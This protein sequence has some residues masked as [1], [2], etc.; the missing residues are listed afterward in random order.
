MSHDT[1]ITEHYAEKSTPKIT[2]VIKDEDGIVIP[3]GSLNTLTLTLY[4]KATDTL[5]GSRSAQQDILEVNG[6]SVDGSGNFAL[7]LTAA[8]MAIVT[9]AVRVETHIALIEWTYNSGLLG[10]KKNIIFKVVNLN[11]VT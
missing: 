11:R 10:N 9:D 3:G 4:D 1:I 7:Q 5:L 8:D 2:A 6:G